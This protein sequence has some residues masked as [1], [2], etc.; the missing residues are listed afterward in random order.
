MG[1]KW[2]R[3]CKLG[4]EW[5]QVEL[6]EREGIAN[7]N[8]LIQH[9]TSTQHTIHSLCFLPLALHTC[10][11]NGFLPFFFPEFLGM[12]PYET[13]ITSP[14]H[15]CLL[16]TSVSLC[17]YLQYRFSIVLF[18]GEDVKSV[19]LGIYHTTS[20]IVSTILRKS[21]TSTLHSS[22]DLSRLGCFGS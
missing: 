11:K 14:W 8:S 7:F 4:L 21:H 3:P 19:K 15:L 9:S 17:T 18:L 20:R 2:R 5:E 12:V 16:L 22:P 1:R 10:T 6:G 13:Y